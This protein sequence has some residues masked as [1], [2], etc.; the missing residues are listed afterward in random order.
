MRV[1]AF[2]REVKLQQPRRLH[3]GHGPEVR[4]F[5]TFRQVKAVSVGRRRADR[6]YSLG[7]T[8]SLPK[9]RFTRTVQVSQKK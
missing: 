4:L 7:S 8:L 6:R 3:V 9:L 1:R 5:A 2:L